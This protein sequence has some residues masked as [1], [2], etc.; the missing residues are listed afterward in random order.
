[1]WEGRE[2]AL[3]TIKQELVCKVNDTRQRREK[4]GRRD[5]NESCSVIWARTMSHL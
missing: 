2:K 1:M 4:L 5:K 3:N